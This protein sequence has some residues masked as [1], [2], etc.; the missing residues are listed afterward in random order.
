MKHQLLA[1]SNF[2][3]SYNALIF[4]NMI[5]NNLVREKLYIFTATSDV[6]PAQLPTITVLQSDQWNNEGN[7]IK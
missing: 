6:T 5:Y 3:L 2:T 4:S 7:V 1:Y